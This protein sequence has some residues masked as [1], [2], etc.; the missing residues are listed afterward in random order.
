MIGNAVVTIL[1]LK[2]ARESLDWHAEVL[3][4]M[5]AT[6]QYSW[7]GPDDLSSSDNIK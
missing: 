2:I 5:S 6:Y 1:L 4:Q 3:N 7:L